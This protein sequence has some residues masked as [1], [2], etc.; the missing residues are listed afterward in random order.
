VAA[1][2]YDLTLSTGPMYKAARKEAF[3]ALTQVIATEP[4]TMLPMVGDIWAK[5]ADFPDADVLAARFKKMLPPNLQEGDAD[6]DASKLAQLAAQLQ[7]LSTQHNQLV[8]ELNRASDTIRTKRLEL[9]S[10]ERI[11]LLGFQ[12]DLVMQELKSNDEAALAHLQATLG[13]IT[14]RLDLIHENMSIDR[15]AGVAPNAPELPNAVEPHVQPITPAAPEQRP[16]PV[17]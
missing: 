4:Q 11:A 1:G 17:G 5:N 16:Q 6:D 12:H 10:K 15:D 14:S 8:A 9:E 3:A 13:A 2:D 7:A